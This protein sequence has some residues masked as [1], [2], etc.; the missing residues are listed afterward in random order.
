MIFLLDEIFRGTN[1]KDRIIGAKSVISNLNKEWIIGLV[2]THDYELCNM[3]ESYPTKIRNFHFT[4][5]YINNE[6][7]FDYTF[8]RRKVLFQ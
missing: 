6:I 8:K 1:S 2:S 5:H 3:K 7:R 4:E